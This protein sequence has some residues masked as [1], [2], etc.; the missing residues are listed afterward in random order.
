[1]ITAGG[2]A[3][4]DPVFTRSEGINLDECL[5]CI[6]SL[7]RFHALS[8]ALKLHEPATFES[9]ANQLQ[10]TYYSARLVPWYQNFMQRLVTISKEALELGCMEDPDDYTASFKRDVLTFLDGDIYGMMVELSNARNH[11]SVFTHGDCWLPNFL[12]HP[13][14]VRMID[15]QMVRCGS[16][17]L[18]IIM[19]VYCCTDQTLR[20]MHYDQLL[21]TYYQSFSEMLTDLGTE[22]QETF[23]ATALAEELVRFGRF[24]CGIAVEAIPL[25]L[26]DGAD[27]PELDSIEGTDA[28]PLE[29]IMTLRSIKTR[30]GRRRLL[31]V[32]R[33]AR[34]CGYI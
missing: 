11:Y 30:Y 8:F 12:F 6:R 21:S 2:V 32:F 24:G 5:R 14:D 15:F 18:D 23:P 17:V 27:V 34:G 20:M 7:G 28:V 29:Q 9:L 25:S 16:P 3:T 26:L 31:D 22:P 4:T 13:Q 19:F 33:H 10:E 1:M